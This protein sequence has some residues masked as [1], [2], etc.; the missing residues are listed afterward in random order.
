MLTLLAVAAVV[1][2]DLM[3]GQPVVVALL[4]IMEYL[5]LEVP[6]VSVQAL[7]AVQA[8]MVGS[9]HLMALLTLLLQ[10]PY[11][12]EQEALGVVVGLVDLLVEVAQQKD[13][14]TS[15]L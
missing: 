11:W 4:V 5:D 10:K 6:E 8:V 1:A 9:F 3:V 12:V 15:L 7:L 13:L 2:L 14:M